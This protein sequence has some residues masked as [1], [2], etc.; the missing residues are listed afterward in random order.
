MRRIVLF[1]LIVF[2]LSSNLQAA[3]IT[4]EQ[5]T[6]KARNYL[7]SIGKS[8]VDLQQASFTAALSRND[9]MACEL[10]LYVF[11]L[12]H[13][14]GFMI[15]S[16]DD[17][18]PEVLCYTDHGRFCY[19]ELPANA[20]FWI[21]SYARQI[22]QLQ[23]SSEA[24]SIAS[25][26]EIH[27]SIAPLL[28]SCWDQDGPYN[29]KC[30][31]FFN[32]NRSMTGCM[33]TAM[34]QVLY[35]YRDKSVSSLQAEI[36]SYDCA[37]LYSYGR[38][39]VDGFA[40]EAPIAWDNMLDRYD[41]QATEVQK[42]AVATLMA[43]CGASIEMNYRDDLNGGST[44]SEISIPTAL[45]KYFG[46]SSDVKVKYRDNF[47][48]D[49][50]DRLIYRE[51]MNG[52]P[53]ILSGKDVSGHG[54]AF[55][56]DGYDG[57]GLYH[58]NWGWGGLADGYYLMSKLQ[59]SQQGIGG[60]GKAYDF[61]LGAV[62][63]MH[64]GNEEPFVDQLRLTVTQL[65]EPNDTTYFSSLSD[66]V[67]CNYHFV[68]ENRTASTRSFEFAL[69]L[70]Q[71]GE[72]IR[73][74][75]TG[76]AKDVTKT[77]FLTSEGYFEW[78]ANTWVK[79]VGVGNYQLKLVSRVQGSEEWLLNE[80][81]DDWYIDLTITDNMVGF[82]AHQFVEPEITLGIDSIPDAGNTDVGIKTLHHQISTDAVYSLTG[83]RLSNNS[84]DIKGLP[85]GIY[86]VGKR[87]IIVK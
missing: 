41:G 71:N 17:T 11:D 7:A 26:I 69:A 81:S 66:I 56:C 2:V 64:P 38:I 65:S 43:Y 68:Q 59:P 31:M 86:V 33:A 13:N 5:A 45:R 53:V 3:H 76:V 1:L 75:I 9:D 79:G 51:L 67:K 21:D 16:G 82:A 61:F 49:N 54:H 12:G 37:T 4:V 44:S 84:A 50:W 30:P 85:A 63:G 58:I 40:A 80:G 27:D 15:L 42:E 83:R 74:L 25:G 36:P 87:K 6:Q 19:E 14:E 57:M 73:N 8:E 29:D 48:D 28:T 77:S 52:R 23:Q 20:R 32:G 62:V 24:D 72:Y 47:S 60:F 39:H 22:A 34:A 18:L 78:L 70:F 10:S 55:V 35:Y 46:Y